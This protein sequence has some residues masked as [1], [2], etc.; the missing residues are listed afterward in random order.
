MILSIDKRVMQLTELFDSF[1][2]ISNAH[3]LGSNFDVV[4]SG[5]ILGTR[6]FANDVGKLKQ[7]GIT[8]VLNVC[9][10]LK[11]TDDRLFAESNIA[12]AHVSFNDVRRRRADC[13]Y[14]FR[15]TSAHVRKVLAIGGK[16]LIYSLLGVNEASAVVIAFMVETYRLSVE[17][18]ALVVAMKRIVCPDN[19]LLRQL[20]RFSNDALTKYLKV[21]N[22]PRNVDR[23]TRFSRILHLIN[24]VGFHRS[25]AYVRD[26][27]IITFNLFLGTRETASDVIQIARNNITHV[28][29]LGGGEN[30][31]RRY[32]ELGIRVTCIGSFENVSNNL[33]SLVEICV[34]YIDDR[35]RSGEKVLVLN[36]ENGCLGELLIAAYIVE[37]HAAN[38]EEALR[39]IA[40]KRCLRIDVKCIQFLLDYEEKLRQRRHKALRQLADD[41]FYFKQCEFP[42]DDLYFLKVCRETSV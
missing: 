32:H 8:H 4:S 25:N 1:L 15:M 29:D 26:M 34:S 24:G 40:Q 2:T 17:R 35:L 21:D 11:R 5:I 27:K 36:K 33:N 39:A 14:L 6:D 3:T 23:N 37:S 12:F 30:V 38:V 10:D 31:D 19:F 41:T 16:I 13:L 9:D 28:L 42:Q 7:L 22:V 20:I 18:A